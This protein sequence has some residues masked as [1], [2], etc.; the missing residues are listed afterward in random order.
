MINLLTGASVFINGRTHYMER[1][2][3]QKLQNSEPACRSN[4]VKISLNSNGSE[5]ETSSWNQ[6]PEE[7]ESL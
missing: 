7:S 6:L 1:F 5:S 4:E 3:V 2:S